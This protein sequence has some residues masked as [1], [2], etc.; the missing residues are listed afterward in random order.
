VLKW[1]KL[2]VKL[3]LPPGDRGEYLGQPWHHFA[4]IPLPSPVHPLPSSIISIFRQFNG[5]KFCN[6]FSTTLFPSTFLSVL[7]STLGAFG[8]YKFKR[9]TSLPSSSMGDCWTVTLKGLI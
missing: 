3:Y 8:T 5:Q 2:P 9:F 1:D 6:L 7:S 4:L